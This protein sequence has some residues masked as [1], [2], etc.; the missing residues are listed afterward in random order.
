MRNITSHLNEKIKSTQQTP[1]YNSDPKMSVKISRARTT[2]MD[3]DYWTVETIREKEGLGD[4]AL[5]P[6]RTISY[7][8][9]NRIYE[10]HVD[11]NTV[12]TAIRDY[13]DYLKSG[14]Q[15]QFELGAGMAVAIAF[16]GH[17]QLYRD[18]WRIV[19]DEEP[20]IFWVDSSGVLWLRLWDKQDTLQQLASSVVKVRA[21]RGWKNVNFAE[22]DQGIIA[23]YI[24]TD[25]K[26]YYRNYC[27]QPD[28]TK[29]WEIERQL[30]EFTYNAM[31]INLFITN[32]YRVGIIVEDSTGNSH[33]YITARNWAGMAIAPDKFYA[34]SRVGVSLIKT[35]R[36]T[37]FHD[38]KIVVGQSTDIAFLYGGSFNEFL[39][40]VNLDDGS[41][42]YGLIIH[43]NTRQ[44]LFNIQLNDFEIFDENNTHFNIG[45]ILK[46]DTK[47][48]HFS[49]EDLNS[50]Y[51]N[52]TI[53][54]KG[55][56]TKNEGGY[57]FDAFSISFVTTGLIP[58]II[59]IP[60]VLEVYN[61]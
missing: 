6:R 22:R 60:E 20:H 39:E 21:I 23:A 18:K 27:I 15:P 40:A 7:G 4:I 38:E 54:C 11:E 3:S 33:W 16:D 37:G 32:D 45:N 56:S 46:I 26:V 2:I 42:N 53:T 19:T 14:W 52:L 5:A 49:V 61:E 10:I 57:L 51:G 17:W 1:T 29:V 30:M 31:N 9:P 28:G 59:P 8:S 36:K 43:V 25:G 24:K 12:K 44:E 50:A 41:G 34:E 35:I 13:P 47:N 58:P 48:Y 55:I